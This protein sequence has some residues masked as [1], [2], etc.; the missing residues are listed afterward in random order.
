M[1]SA[2]HA[3]NWPLHVKSNLWKATEQYSGA[4]CL[5]IQRGSKLLV[6]KS[7]LWKATEQYSGAV[8]FM[9]QCGSKFLVCKSNIWE[10]TEQYSGAVCFVIQCDS[11]VRFVD[12]TMQ[13]DHSMESY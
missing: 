4:V 6:C 5:M 2:N 3:S 12:Q 10:A 11:N 8:C 13:C 1:V 7:N 9:I